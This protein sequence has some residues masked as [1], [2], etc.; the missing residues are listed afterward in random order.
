M[1][2]ARRQLQLATSFAH[3]CAAADA[4]KWD[5]AIAAYTAVADADPG[6]RDVSERLKTAHREQQL[7]GLYA[8]AR[9]LQ[10]AR[11]WAAVLNVGER[12]KAIDPAAADIDVLTTD[13]RAELAQARQAEELAVD[14]R[15]GLR[16]LEAGSWQQAVHLLEQV[17]QRD[18][19]YGDAAALLARA[20][21]ELATTTPAQIGL[22]RLAKQPEV[23][24]TMRHHSGVVNAV[25][26]SPDGR[27]LATGCSDKI[28]R[29]WDATTGQRGLSMKHRA[30]LT[31]ISSVAF[32]ADGS[33]LATV[34]MDMTARIWDTT[35]GQQ[36]RKFTHSVGDNVCGVAFSPDGCWLATA[37]NNEKT[38]RIWDATSGQELRKLRH[39]SNQQAVAFSPDGCWLATACSDKTAWIWDATSGQALRKLT[40]DGPV[41]AVAFSPDG[42]W[43]ATA[44]GTA[45]Q[46]FALEEADHDG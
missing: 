8:E 33:W 22:F 31:G 14:Y 36:L 29:I 20:R 1:E 41:R 39:N 16:L 11:E 46:I 17:S 24:L 18:P 3:A 35:S 4:G 15:T 34:S 42:S 13:A 7:S 30:W 44:S 25:A 27:R 37:A 10:Q 28:A 5:Q 21:R 43:L 32:N 23:A 6:Y 12:I 2:H 40:H 19:A 45:A 9:R 26:F 38:A